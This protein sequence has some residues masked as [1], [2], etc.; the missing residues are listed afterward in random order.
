[1][2]EEFLHSLPSPTGQRLSHRA[3]TLP[4]S[5]LGLNIS[6]KPRGQEVRAVQCECE[7][8]PCQGVPRECGQL[9]PDLVVAVELKQTKW[10]RPQK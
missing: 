5:A 7:M 6:I 8:W 10:P 1:M 2:D 3:S 4:G 9:V